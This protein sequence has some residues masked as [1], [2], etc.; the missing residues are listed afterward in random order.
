MHYI[1]IYNNALNDNTH[2]INN[3][4]RLMENYYLASK[5]IYPF[6]V[7]FNCF[8][9]KTAIHITLKEIEINVEM[10]NYPHT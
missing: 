9:N 3:K 10:N 5:Y 1:Y 6:G 2:L 8:K 7:V 4:R